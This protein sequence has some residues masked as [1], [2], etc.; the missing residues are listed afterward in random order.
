MLGQTVIL[1]SNFTDDNL[2]SKVL[3]SRTVHES[4][5]TFVWECMFAHQLELDNGLKR[6]E[7]AQFSIVEY[8]SETPRSTVIFCNADRIIRLVTL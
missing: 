8:P 2:V 5:C 7:D 6:M 1:I 3:D 4:I